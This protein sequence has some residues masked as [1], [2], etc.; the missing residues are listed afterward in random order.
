MFD[1]IDVVP[2]ENQGT[3]ADVE[4]ERDEGEGVE[5][6]LFDG[7]VQRI[8][9]RD[10]GL[11]EG[12]LAKTRDPRVWLVPRATGEK[13]ERFKAIARTGQEVR[14]GARDRAWGLEVPWRVTIIRGVGQTE[15]ADSGEV[16]CGGNNNNIGLEKAKR[17]KQPGKK[18]RILM[19]Q[20]RKIEIELEEKTR[21]ERIRKEESEKDKKKRKNRERKLKR[22]AKEKAMKLSGGGD[23][24]DTNG[25]D[26]DSASSSDD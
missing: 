13:A 7:Q 23:G 9:L 26:A 8:I 21:L 20:R 18:K 22:R 25:A 4:A 24:G 3:T 12:G 1:G 2:R 6:C 5:F 16:A 11:G 15:I 17:T 19:R 14:N 10:E